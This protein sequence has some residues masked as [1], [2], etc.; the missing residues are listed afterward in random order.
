[1]LLFLKN[2]LFTIL[3]PGSVAVYLPLLLAGERLAAT[4]G[5]R[6]T[7]G[8]LLLLGGTIYGWCLWDF[9]SF[10]RGTPAPIDAPHRLVIRGLYRFTR[11]PMYLGVLVGV[12]GQAVLFRSY[13]VGLYAIGVATCFQLFTVLYEEPHLEQEFGEA[14]RSYCRSTGRWWPRFRHRHVK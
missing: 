4:G 13:A 10:G 9:A 2:L 11:N 1:M 12:L 14:Y 7:A 5:L 8:V 3:I 6:M